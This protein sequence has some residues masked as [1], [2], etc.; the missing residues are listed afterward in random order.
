VNGYVRCHIGFAALAVSAAAAGAPLSEDL[1]SR[2]AREGVVR[3]GT[4]YFARATG[5]LRGTFEVEQ[6]RLA[7]RAMLM[8]ARVMCGFEPSL[9]KRLEAN[10]SGLSVVSSV[11]RGREVEVVLRAPVQTPACRVISAEPPGPASSP[12]ATTPIVSAVRQSL[13]REAGARTGEPVLLRH[14]NIT[15][16]VFNHEY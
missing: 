2:L 4:A 1:Q 10:I 8:L 16:R 15:V 11:Q 5:T 7:T 6:D 9:G 12:L 14:Q 13:T 3:D